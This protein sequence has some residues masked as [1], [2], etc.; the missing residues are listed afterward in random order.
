MQGRIAIFEAIHCKNAGTPFG[1]FW[2]A[3]SSEIPKA[4]Q[5]HANGVLGTPGFLQ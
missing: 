2:C 4:H 1:V 3:I 5:I